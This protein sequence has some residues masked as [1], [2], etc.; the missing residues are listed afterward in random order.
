MH[1]T[2]H[3]AVMLFV[4]VLLV[5]VFCSLCVALSIAVY[6]CLYQLALGSLHVCILATT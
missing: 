4:Y 1:V 2:I 3:G 6:T 5:F